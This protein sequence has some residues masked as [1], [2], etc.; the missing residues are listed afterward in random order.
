MDQLTQDSQESERF[1]SSQDSMLPALVLTARD[2]AELDM[3]EA[4]F[5]AMKTSELEHADDEAD[6][7]R[8]KL[9]AT[10]LAVYHH[11]RCDLY[12]HLSYNARLATTTQI[13]PRIV[14]DIA[15]AQFAKGDTWERH[16]LESLENQNVLTRVD[17]R[18]LMSAEDI[19]K[20]FTEVARTTEDTFIS[21]LSFTPPDFHE[22]FT[23]HNA[24]AVRFSTAKPDLIK[25]RRGQPTTQHRRESRSR[26][27]LVGDVTDVVFWEVIDAKSSSHVKTSHHVQIGFYSRCLEK[28]LPSKFDGTRFA[29]DVASIW[30]PPLGSKPQIIPLAH[31]YD[32]LDELIFRRLPSIVH[33]MESQVKWHFNPLCQ[34][35]AWNPRCRSNTIK[36][37]RLGVIPN[38]PPDEAAVIRDVLLATSSSTDIEDLDK[39]FSN[40]SRV[41]RLKREQPATFRKLKKRFALDRTSSS[42]SAVITAARTGQA[43]VTG[44]R[45]LTFPRSEDIAVVISLALDASS[46]CITHQVDVFFNNGPKVPLK[47]ATDSLLHDLGYI[48]SSLSQSRPNATVQFYTF[49]RAEQAAL[50]QYLIDLA[51]SIELE[52]DHFIVSTAFQPTIL[53]EALTDWLS[54]SSAFKKPELQEIMRRLHLDGN[55]TIAVLRARLDQFIS[56]LADAERARSGQSGGIS[57]SLPRVVVLQEELERLIAVPS[58]GYWELP[59]AVKLLINWGAASLKELAEHAAAGDMVELREAL[60]DRGDACHKLIQSMRIRIARFTSDPASILLNDGRPLP[61]DAFMDLVGDQ[62]LRKLFWMQQ[63]EAFS[64]LNEIWTQR[65]DG[66]PN[67]IL[68]TFDGTKKIDGEEVYCFDVGQNASDT[69]GEREF[70]FFEWLLVEDSQS[71]ADEAPR[72]I[73]F[74]DLTFA[75]V[76]FGMR[77]KLLFDKW[78]S[79]PRVKG[80][81][82]VANINAIESSPQGRQLALRVF[83]P[84]RV[85]LVEGSLYRLTPRLVDFNSA[86]I[87]RALLMLDMGIHSPQPPPFVSFLHDPSSFGRS[88]STF[89]GEDDLAAESKLHNAMRRL[90][91]IDVLGASSLILKDSQRKATRRMISSPLSVI[92]G[93]PGTGK[94]DLYARI[95]TSSHVGVKLC[96]PR[97]IDKAG[98]IRHSIHARRHRAFRNKLEVVTSA[99]KQLPTTYDNRWLTA[100]QT[101]HV[102]QGSSQQKITGGMVHVYLGTAYQLDNFARKSAINADAVFVDEASQMSLGIA[103]LV[104]RWLRRDECKIVCAGDHLQLGTIMAASY[105]DTNPPLFASLLDF[106]IGAEAKLHGGVDHLDHSQSSNISGSVIDTSP[107]MT[108]VKRSTQHTGTALRTLVSQ[109]RGGDLLAAF[110]VALGNAMVPKSKAAFVPPGKLRFGPPKQPYNWQ[111]ADAR[112]EDLPNSLA[113]LRL[114]VGNSYATENLSYEAHVKLEA[115]VAAKL[116]RLIQHALGTDT[117]VFV[118]TPHR[119]Q[120]SSV[121]EA[122]AANKAIE[123]GDEADG[124]GVAEGA[125]IRLATNNSKVRVDTVERLQGQEADVVICCFSHTHRPTLMQH[126]PFLFQ[127]R[128][129]NV[130]ISRAKALCIVL[131]C[132]DVLRPPLDVLSSADSV[133]GYSFL[134]A[135]EDRAWSG[136][137]DIG[138]G[139]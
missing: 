18:D 34:S 100:I 57:N 35:C 9:S 83:P 134:R 37:G 117:S 56:G 64:R 112:P 95:I 61:T 7:R 97:Q 15:V 80:V 79:Q 107:V 111:G 54:K 132:D 129:L 73:S 76:L 47:K 12:L 39:L 90:R 4:Q 28:L 38:I 139:L 70:G 94:Q 26:P 71:A 52:G 116:V 108:S 75:G 68:L 63:F 60:S 32:A 128:R 101:C 105:P 87:M 109:A 65:R 33:G 137:V 91:E 14:P 119:I 3:M 96:R 92:H 23:T 104:L 66:N 99:Y 133:E 42:S 48:I 125:D 36:Q 81:L 13:A 59:E 78:N 58:P 24:R 19:A 30:L 31:I 69:A 123:E 121:K 110:M 82:M 89:G 102:K 41:D 1:I 103:S 40:P 22:E 27:S 118:A 67:A 113:L 138:R 86:K 21:G 126:L 115:A 11:L 77:S 98:H 29:S 6:D 84:P 46:R 5:A 20:L 74:D 10:N 8:H 72:E 50:H 127:R 106:V 93:P 124:N 85:P 120:R 49:S 88:F 16:L 130:G 43:T 114:K 53:Q 51:L 62:T 17:D 45:T 2:M 135:Y 44:R 25:L 122:L 55:G 131:T 136:L